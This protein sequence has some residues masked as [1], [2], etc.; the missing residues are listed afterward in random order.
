MLHPFCGRNRKVTGQEAWIQATVKNSSDP[1]SFLFVKSQT[2]NSSLPY[3][4]RPPCLGNYKSVLCE[5]LLVLI[6]DICDD[7]G[8]GSNNNHN[9][10]TLPE[11]NRDM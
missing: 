2:P 7:D 5:S 8:G 11:S 9:T 6:T 1:V 4:L 3:L 10:L